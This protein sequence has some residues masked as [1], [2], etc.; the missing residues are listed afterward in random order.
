MSFRERRQ[1]TEIMRAIGY[2]GAIGIDSFD[3]PDFGL[4][5]DLLQWLATLYDG[6]MV[7]MAD[8]THEHGRVEFVASIVQQLAI[9]SG[10]RLN[11]R[12]LY[13]SDH[14]AVPQLLKLAAPIYC[15]I[16][17][18][19]TG[20]SADPTKP[21]CLQKI[22]ELSS[23]VPR[24]ACRLS[25]HLTNELMIR[26]SRNRVLAATPPLEQVG[27]SLCSAVDSVMTRLE[28]LTAQLNELKNNE[29]TL[30]SKI[31]QRKSELE[32]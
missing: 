20:S 8:I 22:S 13:A 21:A 9:R 25:D 17:S 10:L 12:K 19:P 6:D 4:M 2:P 11:P 18:T 32:K 30:R 23:T 1:F 31:Q 24:Q 26:E 5:A 16:T 28:T 29:E 15:G 14:H 3:T 7:V 27:K